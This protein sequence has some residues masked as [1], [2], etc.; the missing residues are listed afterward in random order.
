[1][2]ENEMKIIAKIFTDTLKVTKDVK[3]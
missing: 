3:G 1:M 2:K